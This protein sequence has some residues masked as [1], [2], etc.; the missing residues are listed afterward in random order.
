M[1]SDAL[2][3]FLVQNTII[4]IHTF[5]Y[6]LVSYYIE[7]DAHVMQIPHGNS[8]TNQ[9]SYIRTCPSE[10]KK[11][12]CNIKQEDAILA[13]TANTAGSLML[14]EPDFEVGNEVSDEIH[15]AT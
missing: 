13:D 3:K 1:Q 4:L 12:P 11:R 9:K 10:V 2:S 8:R 5:S 6:S 15:K 7:A 14:Q